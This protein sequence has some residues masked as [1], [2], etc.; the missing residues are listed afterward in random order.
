MAR[1]ARADALER[2]PRRAG[3][4]RGGARGAAWLLLVLVGFVSAS[5]A[6][7][8]HLVRQYT[9]PIPRALPT[10]A[11]LPQIIDVINNNSARVQS[12]ST[13]RATISTP[14]LPSLSANIAF[15]RPRSFRLVAQKFGPEVDLGSNDTVLWF[16]VKRAQ[17][18][19]LLY[20]RHDQFATSAAR[21]MIPVEPEWLIE[22][23]GVVT[24]EAAQVEGPMP[25]GK[26][27]VE[28]RSKAAA[29]GG[30]SKVTII[31]DSRGVVLEQHVYDAQGIRL[32][33]A[34]LSKNVH[35]PATGVTLPRHV[36][37]EWPP[38]KFNLSV[39]MAELLVNQ[40]PDQPELFTQPVYNG[41]NNI[42]LAQ[43]S[44]QPVPSAGGQYRAPPTA[45]Y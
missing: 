23:M 21:Q 44:G 41:Y 27:R 26:G 17:P 38:T 3:A 33:T 5:G 37:I 2:T 42:D 30:V 8:P 25:V 19:A 29:P 35:D 36:E 1:M 32:A 9:Q 43:P 16:W 15:Q 7:C 28:L 4:V 31:D 20:C 12:L 11:S 10:S 6:S 24:L 45:R 22:A 13:T 18:P 40:L 14:G 34:V 39:E